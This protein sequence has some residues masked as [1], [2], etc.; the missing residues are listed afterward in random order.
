MSADFQ[1]IKQEWNER[2][3]LKTVEIVRENPADEDED[4]PINITL[5]LSGTRH[6][7]TVGE[8]ITLRGAVEESLKALGE[9]S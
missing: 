2:E 3:V 1:T 5:N 7:L 8:W 4:S 6:K 9:M